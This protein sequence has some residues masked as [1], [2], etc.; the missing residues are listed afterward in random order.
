[1]TGAH[2]AS[3]TA[4]AGVL[5]LNLHDEV[6][7]VQ[8]VGD[9]VWSLPETWVQTGESPRDAARRA[10]REQLRIDIPL[11][12]LLVL[13]WTTDPEELHLV[14]DGGIPAEVEYKEVTPDPR[15]V[16]TWTYADGG[17]APVLLRSPGTVHYEA[18]MY[19]QSEKQRGKERTA[20]LENGRAP[21]IG[22]AGEGGTE[23]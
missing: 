3:P 13:N 16:S 21:R 7:L 11:G 2:P 5:L 1:M 12:R 10:V 4:Y 18:A 23:S 14:Y 8:N 15:L 20:Y 9:G 17:Q 19:V 6:L 22:N